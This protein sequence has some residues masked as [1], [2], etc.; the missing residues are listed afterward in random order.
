MD[1]KNHPSVGAVLVVEA[2]RVLVDLLQ[3]SL[4]RS[5]FLV[6]A[7]GNP[8]DIPVLMEEIHP[9]VILLDLFMPGWNGL[10]VLDEMKQMGFLTDSR[11]IVITSFGFR[12]VLQQAILQGAVDFV[13]KPFDIDVLLDKVNK[14]LF[15]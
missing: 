7:T 5:G 2:D 6:R 4:T 8:A 12:E 15:W 10:E 9:Q 11:V 14:Y 1:N 3:L 13:V